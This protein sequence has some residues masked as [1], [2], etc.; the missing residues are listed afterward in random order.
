MALTKSSNDK[1]DLAA[2][3]NHVFNI[4]PKKQPL[5]NIPFGTTIAPE[6]AHAC[7]WQ[8]LTTNVNTVVLKL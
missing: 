5:K 3:V 6:V 1:F 4:T 2:C 7:F 8:T